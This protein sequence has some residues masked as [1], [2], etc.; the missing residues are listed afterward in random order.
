[1]KK[2][3]IYFCERAFVAKVA[4]KV[5]G[6]ANCAIV[7][8]R[9]IYL[10]QITENEIRQNEALLCHELTHVRQWQKFGVLRF[11][12]LYLWYSLKFGYYNN[13]FEQEA[14][15]NENNTAII[16]QFILP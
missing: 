12:V 4:A 11:P 7:F 6:N 3:P 8:R 9:T 2:T 16:D 5:L 13:P 14:R 1:M 15:A 10:H